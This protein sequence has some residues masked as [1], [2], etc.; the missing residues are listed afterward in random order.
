M[1]RVSAV[2]RVMVLSSPSLRV[3][4]LQRLEEGSES[5]LV[6]GGPRL[7]D[8]S[9][10]CSIPIHRRYGHH[11][12]RWFRCRYRH[13]NSRMAPTAGPQP[14]ASGPPVSRPAAPG[15]C[16]RIRRS[17]SS[18]ASSQD[19][20]WLI[21]GGAD[22]PGRR[23]CAGTHL[24]LVG[25]PHRPLAEGSLARTSCPGSPSDDL[26]GSRFTTL[27]STLKGNAG[28]THS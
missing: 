11:V 10:L 14:P 8:E 16:R 25:Q 19:L 4:H 12:E 27:A 22:E 20:Y 28:G 7:S 18:P 2:C 1:V 13:E 24:H 9:S 21:G 3:Q 26:P 15:P 23:S 17:G 5:D 6:A